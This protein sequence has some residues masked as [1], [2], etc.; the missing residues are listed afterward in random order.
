MRTII[1]LCCVVLLALVSGCCG[2]LKSGPTTQADEF[3]VDVVTPALPIEEE[4]TPEDLPRPT[5]RLGKDGRHGGERFFARM[6]KDG[7]GTISME[8]FRGSDERF[9]EVD[10]DGDGQIGAAEF[11]VAKPDRMSRKGDFMGRHDDDEDGK[12]SAEEFKGKE[13][14]FT[15]LDRN[16]DGF[17]DADEAPG[18]R[19]ASGRT[20]DSEDE[21]DEGAEDEAEGEA[22]GDEAAATD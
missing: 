19:Q 10:T 13:T 7:S 18:G 1:P 21:G 12:I 3:E 17:I 8:E 11:D 22:E 15:K 14:R 5:K 4:A 20:S 9:A 16:G 2:G 6:D